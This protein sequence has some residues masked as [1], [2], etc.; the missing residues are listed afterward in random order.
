[1]ATR[2]TEHVQLQRPNAKKVLADIDCTRE[3]AQQ[4]FSN[5]RW[6]GIPRIKAVS[7]QPTIT[8]AGRIIQRPGLDQESG[9]YVASVPSDWEPIPN[10]VDDLN[11]FRSV[12]S[13]CAIVNEYQFTRGGLGCSGWMSLVLTGVA[14]PAIEGPTPMF[15]T[16]AQH[17]AAGK[18]MFLDLASIIASGECVDMV[19]RG[20]SE[21]N[22]KLIVSTIRQGKTWLAFD[23]EK[24]GCVF[25]CPVLASTLTK[26][27]VAGRVLGASV[28][29][30]APN[31][32]LIC[33]SGNQLT[34]STEIARRTLLIEID[35]QPGRSFTKTDLRK[36]VRENRVRLLRDALI[37]LRYGLSQPRVER[38]PLESYEEWSAM[39]RDTILTMEMPDPCDLVN[40]AKQKDADEDS[41][42]ML[43][44]AFIDLIHA[45]QD[46]EKAIS[47]GGPR[48]EHCGAKAIGEQV[49]LAIREFQRTG[50]S[51]QQTSL[52]MSA[53]IVAG[54]CGK[55]VTKFCNFDPQVIGR[56]L[57]G[58][59]NR[60]VNGKRIVR[61]G[62]HGQYRVEDA[63]GNPV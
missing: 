59:V 3:L 12:E 26:H 53:S 19:V 44:E 4:V 14:R 1:M 17:P 56:R 13:L 31:R 58:L 40:A 28:T 20:S 22:Q 62:R 51:G 63:S 48:K 33:A 9:I 38:R 23:N 47:P 21:E 45:A 27:Q 11:A 32:L 8:P 25:A 43:I 41:D 5:Q 10:R 30:R 15:V 61:G 42:D 18:S 55:S 60:E 49:M 36:W 52:C 54:R 57:T 7:Q 24:Q 29:V 34:F 6:K 16:E 50:D 37:I 35:H 46:N 39:I 2:V